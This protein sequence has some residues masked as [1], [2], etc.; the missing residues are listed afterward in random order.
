MW[1]KYDNFA[2]KV[3]ENQGNIGQERVICKVGAITECLG[4]KDNDAIKWKKLMIQRRK[5]RIMGQNIFCKQE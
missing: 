5:G 3:A 2:I 4:V 1:G